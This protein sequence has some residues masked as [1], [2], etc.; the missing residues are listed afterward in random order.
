MNI[1]NFI[2]IIPPMGGNVILGNK[3]RDFVNENWTAKKVARKYLQLIQNSIPTDWWYD[4]NKITYVHGSG[5]A[6]K[7]TKEVIRSL[8]ETG[9]MKALQLSDKPHLEKLMMDFAYSLNL[10]RSATP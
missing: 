6:E 9:G 1:G 5:L 10:R 4:P 7:R 2:W 3:N 8:V